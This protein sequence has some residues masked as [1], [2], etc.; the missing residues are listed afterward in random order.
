MFQWMVLKSRTF[1]E[2]QK[3]QFLISHINISHIYLFVKQL[4]AL[5]F[6]T[7]SPDELS[8]NGVTGN[9]L[10]VDPKKIIEEF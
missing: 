9:I 6:K 2:K 8:D 10:A 7:A 5:N 4:L 3:K 1:Y